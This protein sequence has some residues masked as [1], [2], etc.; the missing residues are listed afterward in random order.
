LQEAEVDENVDQR[1]AVGDGLLVAEVGAFDAQRDG[2]A[3]NAL[4]GGALLVDVLVS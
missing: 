1:V 4:G 2:L 3:V